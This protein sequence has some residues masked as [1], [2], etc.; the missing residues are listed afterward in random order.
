[1]N[2]Q[3]EMVDAVHIAHGRNPDAGFNGK[4]SQFQIFKKKSAMR[5]QLDKPDRKDQEFKIGCLYLQA[6]PAKS[7]NKDDGFDWEDKKISVKIGVNDITAILHGFKTGE[8][9]KMFHEFN[10]DTKTIA[11]NPNRE[12]GGY[13]L[14]LEHS[15]KEG[16]KNRIAIPLTS[17]ES[18]SLEVML[19]YALPK[20]HN[21]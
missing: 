15:T 12:R 19:N 17:A 5:I 14:Q 2:S 20:I 7:E 13:F 3:K 6:A 9:S 1:M 11:F 16:A 8:G 10:G 4:T 18:Y 21:W